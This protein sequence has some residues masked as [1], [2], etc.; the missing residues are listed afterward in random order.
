[1]VN[2]S[3]GS[4]FVALVGIDRSHSGLIVLAI[5]DSALG[6]IAEVDRVVIGIENLRDSFLFILN[7]FLFQ[8]RPSSA[9]V[10]PPDR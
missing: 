10:N 9:P 5:Y 4:V 8:M 7:A 2:V 3:K 6:R 1:M